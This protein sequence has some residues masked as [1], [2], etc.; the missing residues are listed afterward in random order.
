MVRRALYGLIVAGLIASCGIFGYTL[1]VLLA[2][3]RPQKLQSS[4]L[5]LAVRC[6][7]SV[8][9][10]IG[11]SLMQNEANLR[12]GKGK[13]G[14]DGTEEWLRI[15][16]KDGT[17]TLPKPNEWE[18]FGFYQLRHHFNCEGLDADTKPLP[19]SQD[20]AIYKNMYK[21]MVDEHA[22]FDD[23]VPSTEG[24]TL[25]K[26]GPP[27]FYAALGTRG[28]GLF[29][30]RDIK[31]GELV[32]D[33]SSNDLRFPNALAW[34]R[35]VFSLPRRMACDAID[36][37]WTQRQGI[38]TAMNTSILMNAAN[39]MSEKGKTEPNLSASTK[40]YATRDIKK[41]EELLYDYKDRDKDWGSVCL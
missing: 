37:T 1:G 18:K 3:D 40:M 23:S 10:Q 35:Y 11:S 12:K 29:A 19:T 6:G 20:W 15:L 24:Y 22:I 32:H 26:I 5:S 17:N 33:G 39:W 36:W 13:G 2:S 9:T 31:K 30:S 28:R 14:V 34:R 16:D 21:I 38:L 25:N 7:N 41:G 27:P 4:S 8:Q